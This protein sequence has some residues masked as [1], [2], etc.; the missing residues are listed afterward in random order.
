MIIALQMMFKKIQSKELRAQ[1]CLQYTSN[2]HESEID[3]EKELD[4]PSKAK[5]L[6]KVTVTIKR[7]EIG[8]ER[9]VWELI[10]DT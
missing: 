2:N 6:D 9:W 10:V 7:H 8:R 4:N 5:A 3:S 1:F